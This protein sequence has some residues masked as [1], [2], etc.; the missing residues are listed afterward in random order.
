MSWG[1]PA[2]AAIAGALTT[3]CGLAFPPSRRPFAEAAFRRAIAAAGER[4]AGDY[5]A[6]LAGEPE[7]L[8]ALI[9]E[10]S[11]GETYFFRDPA[12]FDVIRTNVLPALERA[13]AGERPLRVWSAGC[14]TGEEAYSLA[15][16]LEGRGLLERTALFASDVSQRA[17][18]TARRG[19]YGPWSFRGSDAAW[20]ERCFG[21]SGN[22]WS[23]DARFRRVD[24]QA[25][26][27][28]HGPLGG[29][30]FDLI[31]CRN[32]LLYFEREALGRVAATLAA[33]LVP[34]GWLVT[35]PTDPPL[36]GDVGLEHV[37]TPAGIMYRRPA[38]RA[39]PAPALPAVSPPAAVPAV[40]PHHARPRRTP[41]R[42]ADAETHL[43]RALM[44][45]DAGQPHQAA[46]AARRA[47]FL[48]RSL[49]VAQLTLARALRLTGKRAAAQRA[50]ERSIALL[51]A[52]PA[53]DAVR[54]G[55]GASAGRLRA[56][57]AAEL[58]LLA[59]REVS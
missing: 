10:A 18:Q 58:N 21:R 13:A 9:A 59:R 16:L 46:V 11:V 55:G 22:R 35:S 26:N 15:M 40:H 47:L 28:L 8:A 19:R 56:V 29:G 52:L 42:A 45:L 27:L 38:A 4:R 30:G 37:V 41:V 2:F 20:R 43:A 7:L 54:G 23:I 49:A 51:D 14:S 39:L 12:Q 25:H 34:G 53:H 17:L 32:V 31:V 44:L 50:L 6:R 1:E 57:A 36:P 48:D 3:A 5:A 24:F 33:A